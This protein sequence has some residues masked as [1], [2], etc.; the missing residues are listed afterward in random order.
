MYYKYNDFWREIES[1]TSKEAADY[2]NENI[3][4]DLLAGT[5]TCVGP[6]GLIIFCDDIESASKC[7]Q[8][9]YDDFHAQSLKP[10]RGGKRPG[11]GRPRD[12][13]QCPCGLMAL[14]RA[15]TRCHVIRN[16]DGTLACR[17]VKQKKTPDE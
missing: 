9:A 7:V 2:G 5:R 1:R 17:P 15:F 13:K 14:T 6:S 10:G 11:A 12:A 4:E 3:D 16:E 8:E